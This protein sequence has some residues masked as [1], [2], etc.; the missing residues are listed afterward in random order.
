MQT[1]PAPNPLDPP[2]S[3]PWWRF[4]M[5]WF[6]L[7]GPALVVVAGFATMAIAFIHADIESTSRRRWRR[8]RSGSARKAACRSAR[9]QTPQT[10]RHQADDAAPPLEQRA[11]KHRVLQILWPAFLVAGVMEILLF[12][13]FD[14][15]DVRWF[16]GC[17]AGSP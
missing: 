4:G 5:V 3:P 14:P 16:G 12:S 13:I 6:V 11:V 1:P 2:A 17:S 9:A 7:S 10:L 15:A 8:S